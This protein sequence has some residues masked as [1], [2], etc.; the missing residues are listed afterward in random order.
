MK[1]LFI[2]NPI[3]GRGSSL[4]AWRRI[5]RIVARG[6]RVDA[7]VPGSAAETRSVA[8]EAVRSGFE[9]V[10][11]VGGD[12]TLALVAAELANSDVALGMIPAGT[13]NDFRRSLGIPD[14]HAAALEIALQAHTRRVDLGQVAGERHFLNAA[15]FGFDAE[16]AATAASLPSGLGGTLPYLLGA[17]ATLTRFRPV[18]MDITVD[19]QTLSGPALLVAVANGRFYGG[20]MQ[21]A[22]SARCDDGQFDI[23]VVGDLG[24]LELLRVLHRV[25]SGTHVTHPKVRMARG[26]DVRIR[27]PKPDLRLHLD[28]ELF[29]WSSLDFQVLPGALAVAAP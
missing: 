10:V 29:G 13:G 23:C 2:V 8:T 12:G 25:Y 4:R 19:G 7:V 11:V 27:A 18:P 9:R 6:R 15:G 1:V 5:S 14:D 3:A 16:V 20:G 17:L 28:G 22:P 24:R 26:R 21:I